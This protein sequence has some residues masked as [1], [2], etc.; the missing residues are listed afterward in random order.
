M[1]QVYVA[2][3]F[4]PD[5]RAGSGSQG[6]TVAGKK[7]FPGP[8][9][10]LGAGRVLSLRRPSLGGRERG[11]ETRGADAAHGAVRRKPVAPRVSLRAGFE[12]RFWLGL[13]PESADRPTLPGLHRNHCLSTKAR[14]WA[15]G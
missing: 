13:P 14:H 4:A 6:R 7:S 1:T 10:P 8:F 9:S 3:P 15:G 11:G 2:E 5:C 12:V